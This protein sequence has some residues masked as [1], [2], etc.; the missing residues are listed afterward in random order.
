MRRISVVFNLNTRYPAIFFT[1]SKLFKISQTIVFVYIKFYG[2]I[3]QGFDYEGNDPFWTVTGDNVTSLC[4]MDYNADGKNEL[5]VG[6]E[7]FEIR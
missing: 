6:S 3:F 2:K 4:L 5:I 1:F 7:D